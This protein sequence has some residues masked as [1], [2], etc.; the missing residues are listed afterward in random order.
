MNVSLDRPPVGTDVC[1]AYL[2]D[3]TGPISLLAAT[4]GL[5]RE[6]VGKLRMA[7]N[8]GLTGWLRNKCVLWLSSAL[9]IILASSSS[10]NW[11]RSPANRSWAF[12]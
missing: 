7:V 2:L 12:R 11:E 3:R 4:I 6:C 10:A 5:R 8:E 9:R 1:S